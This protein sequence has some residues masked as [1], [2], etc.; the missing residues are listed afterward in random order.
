[1]T[2][3]LHAVVV[4]DGVLKMRWGYAPFVVK[5]LRSE[6]GSAALDRICKKMDTGRIEAGW[7]EQPLYSSHA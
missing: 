1:M 6:N 2:R 4:P 5:H 3:R 7:E